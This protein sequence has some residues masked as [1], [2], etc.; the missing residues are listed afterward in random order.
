MSCIQRAG[1]DSDY[2]FVL[3]VLNDDSPCERGRTWN[4]VGWA[5]MKAMWDELVEDGYASN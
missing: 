2:W 5:I 3:E 1:L 4:D